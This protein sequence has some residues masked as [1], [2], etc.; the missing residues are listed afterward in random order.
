MVFISVKYLSYLRVILRETVMYMTIT[1]DNAFSCMF[2][3]L[4]EIWANLASAIGVYVYG[5][6]FLNWD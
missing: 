4:K 5:M 3:K 2:R 1:P 6:K